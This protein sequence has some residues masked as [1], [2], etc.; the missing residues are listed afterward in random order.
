MKIIFDVEEDSSEKKY[1]IIITNDGWEN[2]WMSISI[3]DKIYTLPSIE[4]EE[5]CRAFLSNRLQKIN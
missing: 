1:E 4:F 5:V 2:D 3:N